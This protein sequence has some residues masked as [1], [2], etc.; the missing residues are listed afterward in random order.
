MSKIK[1]PTS[2]QF[3]IN[4]PNPKK[5]KKRPNPKKTLKKWGLHTDSELTLNIFNLPLKKKE[6]K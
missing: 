5:P 2:Y 6:E 4:T 1:N 3:L